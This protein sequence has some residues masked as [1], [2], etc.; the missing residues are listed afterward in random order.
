M[1]KQLRILAA[2]LLPITLVGC[3]SSPAGPGV[4]HV[5]TPSGKGPFPAVIVLHTHGGLQQ[6]DIDAARNLSAQG[7]VTVAADFHAKGG[8]D[9]ID[10]AYDF[11]SANPA[12]APGRIGLLG[13]SQG[14]A[15]AIKFAEYSHRFTERRI[16]AIVSYFLG[17]NP[18]NNAAELPPILFLQGSLDSHVSPAR[19]KAYCDAQSKL[20]AHCELVRYEG[21][22]HAFDRHTR[23]YQGY[24]QRAAADAFAR[25]T[26]FFGKYLKDL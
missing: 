12:V 1:N 26:A 4:P 5:F 15:E 19:L 20:G 2:L 21:T 18:G 9:N 13:F 8:L 16:G 24:D 17:P 6:A 11:L 23:N 7:Y 10:K 14:A 25:T 3:A 22:K